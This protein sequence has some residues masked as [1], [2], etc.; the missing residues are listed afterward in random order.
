MS[1]PTYGEQL[2]ESYLRAHNVEFEREPELPGISQR[3]DYVVDHPTAGK[4]LLEVKDIEN[5]VSDGFSQFSSYA[6]LRRHIDEARKKFKNTA[7]YLCAL[8]LVAPPGS[9]V[10]FRTP[11][12]VLGSMYGNFGFRIPIDVEQGRAD[13]EGMT[14]EFQIGKGKMVQRGRFQNTRIAVIITVHEWHVL[15]LAVRKYLNT[16]DGRTRKER[17]IDLREGNVEF[18]DGVV[19]GVTVWENAV[20]TRKLPQDMFRGEMDAWWEA[21]DDGQELTFIGSM[22]RALGVDDRGH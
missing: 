1:A 9:L 21:F 6:A 22:R 2:F 7:D 16:D 5:Q 10:D 8:V 3:V 17:Y 20:A 15:N 18:P 12:I 4:V 19:L 13:V 11:E 14:T